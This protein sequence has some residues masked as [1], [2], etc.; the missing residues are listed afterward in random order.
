MRVLQFKVTGIMLCLAHIAKNSPREQHI[1]ASRIY[2]ASVMKLVAHLTEDDARSDRPSSSTLHRKLSV[3]LVQRLGLL[4]LL[5]KVRSWR[6]SRGLRSLELN[7]QSLG[8]TA[9]ST[10]TSMPSHAQGASEDDDDDDST[11]EVVEELEQIVEVLLCGLRDKDTVVRWS[12][13]KGIGR[14]TGRL[15]YEFADDIVQSVLELSWRRRAMELGME[16]V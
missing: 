2:F 3:K 11:F 5:P 13:A 15:P 14:I 12:A 1:E 16:Q 9:G 4:Y 7:M 8:L 6:Y 10:V